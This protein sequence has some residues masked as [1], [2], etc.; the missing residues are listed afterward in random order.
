MCQFVRNHKLEKATFPLQTN[1]RSPIINRYAHGLH[2]L[3]VR[4]HHTDPCPY[5]PTVRTYTTYTCDA[6]H[7]LRRKACKNMHTH[8]HHTRHRQHTHT[9]THSQKNARCQCVGER[10]HTFLCTHAHTQHLTFAT[11][12]SHYDDDIAA[13]VCSVSIYL[14]VYTRGQN[15]LMGLSPRVRI[16]TAHITTADDSQ[17]TTAVINIVYAKMQPTHV[18]P[19]HKICQGTHAYSRALRMHGQMWRGEGTKRTQSHQIQHVVAHIMRARKNPSHACIMWKSL[20]HSILLQCAMRGK[21][22]VSEVNAIHLLPHNDRSRQWQDFRNTLFHHRTH[23]H[24]Y[25]HKHPQITFE[26]VRMLCY[27]YCYH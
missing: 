5:K 19:P 22:D 14:W 25:A 13:R 9:H 1:G 21:W 3:F 2:V 7:N 15:K 8:N 12:A 23:T 26:C 10:W 17:H 16:T 11:T 20:M 24:T 4:K 18:L 27:Y 6:S